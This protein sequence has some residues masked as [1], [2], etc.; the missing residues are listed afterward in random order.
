MAGNWVKTVTFCWWHQPLICLSHALPLWVDVLSHNIRFTGAIALGMAI[1]R[2][3]HALVTAWR[4][5]LI[6]SLHNFWQN[7]ADLSIKY[8]HIFL[9]LLIK[10]SFEAVRNI[11]PIYRIRAWEVACFALIA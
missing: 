3:I 8:F 10:A 1:A 7:D 9:V 4:T 11:R 6:L 5:C 2:V